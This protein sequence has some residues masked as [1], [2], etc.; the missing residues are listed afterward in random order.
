MREHSAVTSHFYVE[1]K[2]WPKKR[3]LIAVFF[4]WIWEQWSGIDKKWNCSIL[5]QVGRGI[6]GKKGREE[7]E[8]LWFMLSSNFCLLHLNQC[9]WVLPNSFVIFLCIAALHSSFSVPLT[10]VSLASYVMPSVNF[11]NVKNVRIQLLELSSKDSLV[12][13]NLYV[14]SLPLHWIY[15]I[16]L[17]ENICFLIK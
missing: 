15:C 1:W 7:G 14:L 11:F 8:V 6:F 10:A 9:P 2:E 17:R 4:S 13:Q 5:K 16:I 12:L 3:S